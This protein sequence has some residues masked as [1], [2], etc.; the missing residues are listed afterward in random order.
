M[1][2]NKQS[3]NMTR[4]CFGIV[5]IASFVTVYFYNVLTPYMSDDL[6]FDTSIYHSIWDV[7][8]EEYKQYMNW[9]GRSVLQ[10]I[11]KFAMLM[12][13]SIFNILNS[14]C[15]VVTMLLIYLNIKGRKKYDVVLYT[16]INLCVWIFC[17]D[18]S[19]T[20]LWVAGACNYLWG[21]FIILG[22]ITLFRWY[23]KN[24]YSIK[25]KWLSGI[26]LFTTGMIA[27]WG[28]ENTSG[29]MILIVLLFTLKHYVVNKKI[30][31]IMYAG[32]VGNFIGFAFLLLAPGNVGRSEMAKAAESYS[33]IAAYVSRGLKVLK[34]I[35]EHL[36]IYVIVICLLGAYFYYSKKYKLLD[37]TEV[38]I[39]SFASIATAVVLIMTP[40][41]M[42]RAYFGANIYMMIAALQ[43][44]QMIREDDTLLLSLKTGGIIAGAIA[45]MF[46]YVEEGANLVRIRRE[47][48]IREDYIQ[49][50]VA[51][52]ESDLILPMLRPEFET[53]YSMAHLCDISP[54]EDN[55]NN[56][57]YRNTYQFLGMEVLPWDEWEEVTGIEE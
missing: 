22:F 23:L 17:V 43:M 30:E 45:M 20:I 5:V 36:L 44:I 13:K 51:T 34:A 29:G 16:L 40:E 42:A 32:I 41:P 48:S 27:G 57:I 11:L 28:N 21:V 15:Y 38:A 35:D 25:N 55:W 6:L 39:F 46:V 18:F 14:L 52:G 10:I 26:L 31:K 1:D 2:K 8:R 56:N 7:F 49:E 53:K 3:V 12:P 54:D 47:I 50:V 33:G 4:V 37:F 9:N 24:S 19:Q